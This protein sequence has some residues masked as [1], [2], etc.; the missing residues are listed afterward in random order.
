M[1]LSCYCRF[2]RVLCYIAELSDVC[3]VYLINTQTAS[4]SE[5][6][7]GRVGGFVVKKVSGSPALSL[8]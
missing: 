3:H 1:Y 7:A 6:P 5:N 4:L 2:L 8:F